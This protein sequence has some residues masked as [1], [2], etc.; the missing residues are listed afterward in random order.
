[1]RDPQEILNDIN[2]VKR[3]LKLA[4]RNKTDNSRSELKSELNDLLDEYEF[5]Y[6][7]SE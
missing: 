1:M 3:E 6:L 2:A 7:H 4:K 5:A